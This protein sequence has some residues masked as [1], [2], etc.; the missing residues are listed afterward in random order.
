[1]FYSTTAKTNLALSLPAGR[2]REAATDILFHHA[3]VLK[4]QNEVDFLHGLAASQ[5]QHA[6]ARQ[7]AWLAQIAKRAGVR[8]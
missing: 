8:L 6:T 7:Y 2:H 1:M 4:N 5:F 3:D